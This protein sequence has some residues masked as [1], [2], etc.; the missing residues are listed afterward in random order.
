MLWAFWCFGVLLAGFA[1]VYLLRP[2]TQVLTLYGI[3][4][5]NSAL[6]ITTVSMTRAWRASRKQWQESIWLGFAAGFWIWLGAGLLE[7]LQYFL[8]KPAYVSYGDYLWA[9]GYL[10]MF[11]GLVPQ[12][13]TGPRTG[14]RRTI[15]LLLFLSA[16]YFAGLIFY[17]WPH[18][19]EPSRDLPTKVIDFLYL[20][21]N[22]L[23]LGMILKVYQNAPS[24]ESAFKMAFR[25]LALAIII[26]TAAD[27]A[28]SYF[29]DPE[30]II[31]QLL[32]LPYFLI[33]FL[34]F[35]AGLNQL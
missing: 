23:L 2:E 18:L 25:E 10:P 31:F 26:M 14:R 17:I 7:W 13:K 16:G 3:L 24:S 33:Y 22:F 32:D 27:I 35:L 6:V 4:A 19:M 12:L 21:F 34:F 28:L 20:T 30:S 1:F 9:I 5:R 15:F 11:S 8:H 29:V